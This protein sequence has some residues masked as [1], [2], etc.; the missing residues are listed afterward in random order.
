[1]SDTMTRLLLLNRQTRSGS[2]ATHRVINTFGRLHLGLEEYKKTGISEIA[3]RTHDPALLQSSVLVFA[4]LFF[5]PSLSWRS[6]LDQEPCSIYDLQKNFC[7]HILE[8]DLGF[9]GHSASAGAFRRF[10]GFD[11][12]GDTEPGF[13][14]RGPDAQAKGCVSRF[15]GFGGFCSLH[16]L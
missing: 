13:S 8:E 11:H 1:M 4:F 16:S 10:V 7:A 2:L 15:W 3:R 14:R 12:E 6:G 9:S 5:F